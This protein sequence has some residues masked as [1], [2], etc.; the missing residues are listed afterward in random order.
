MTQIAADAVKQLV[1]SKMQ[2][3]EFSKKL[4]KEDKEKYKDEIKDS[5]EVVKKLDSII[6]LYIG[7][8]DKRQGITR[9]LEVSVMQRIGTANWYSG[10]RPN[11][12]TSTEEQLIQQAKDE[13]EKAL[14][15]TN[16]FYAKDWVEYK[17]KMEQIELSQF[18]ETKIFTID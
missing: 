5:G 7:K 1:E 10:S 15:S 17:T 18:K 9:N 8:E 12:L 4:K 13:L 3:E 2:A 11:G 16:A 6:A 14:Q